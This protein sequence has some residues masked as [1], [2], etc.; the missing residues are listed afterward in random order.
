MTATATPGLDLGALGAWF[1]E[2]VP[3]AGTEL[4]ATL[5]AG[6]KSNLT[7]AVTD[8]AHEWIV[9]RP[10]LGHVLAT[11]HDMGREHRV[12]SALQGTGVPVPRTYAMCTD[13]VVTGSRP[14]SLG[15]TASPARAATHPRDL[16]AARRHAVAL[17]AVDPDAVGL[18]D[19]GRAEGF[20]GRQV[21]RWKKQ[22]DASY[23]REL[24]AADELLKLL[25]QNVP[26][27]SASG[28]VQFGRLADRYGRRRLNRT[29]LRRGAG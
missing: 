16:R 5:I 20:L 2:H 11:A 6:G 1:A 4:Q 24:P 9:R 10:P 19:F 13:P 21:R 28:I 7:Y 18:A 17:H 8:G 15:I 26:A 22:L 25:E 27:E 12:M 23:N 14:T 3:G 29:A